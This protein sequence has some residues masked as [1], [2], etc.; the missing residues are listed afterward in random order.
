MD[1]YNY[2]SSSSVFYS[3]EVGGSSTSVHYTSATAGGYVVDS[4]DT[5]P[6]T[7]SA[8]TTT[9][10]PIVPT[11]RHSLSISSMEWQQLTAPLQDPSVP[12]RHSISYPPPRPPQHHNSQQAQDTEVPETQVEEDYGNSTICETIL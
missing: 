11:A 2:N 12:A 1:L 4:T 10:A 7:Y 9:I 8:Y 5:I 3:F 6:F